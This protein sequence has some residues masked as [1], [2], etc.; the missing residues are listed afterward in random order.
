MLK[1]KS[2]LTD[3]PEFETFRKTLNSKKHIQIKGISGSF[4]SFVLNFVVDLF[5]CKL[6]AIVPDTEQAEKL[7]DDLQSLMPRNR[8]I[9]FPQAEVVPFDKGSFAP[10]IHSARLKA[11][12]SL[13]ENPASIIVTTPVGLLQKIESPEFIK[14]KISYLK[15]GDEI[16][17][18]FLIEW[19]FYTLKF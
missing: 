1:L 5:E 19:L 12:V 10:A 8:A 13:L 7:A 3:S 16:E 9:Y 4:L 11:L 15:V 17:R 14:K 2:I 6:L 18:N